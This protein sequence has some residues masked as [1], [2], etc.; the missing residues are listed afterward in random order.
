MAKKVHDLVIIG[1]GPAAL[2]AAIYTT[3]EDVETLLLEKLTVGGL[4]ATT[5]MIDNY[6]GFPDGV[7]GSELSNLLEKQ[8]KKFGSVIE[9]GTV[10]SIKNLGKDKLLVVDGSE[11]YA[12][13]V[14]IATGSDYN[15]LNIPGEKEYYGR[16]VHFCATC[17]G[18]FYRGRKIIV[19]G[20]GNSAFQESIYLTRFVE[21]ID[22]VVR[23]RIRASEILQ[24]DIKKYVDEGKITIHIGYTTEEIIAENNKVSG[25]IV[26]KDDKKT[27]I[28]ADGVFIFAGL[29]PN[30]AFLNSSGVELDELGF[31]KTDIRL[32]TNISGVFACGDVRSGATMQIAAAVGEGALAAYSIRDYLMELSKQNLYIA[33]A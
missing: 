24:D 5:D 8:A 29:K 3:R 6:P 28:L 10:E 25:V 9:Y 31:I 20:G 23:S 13:S 12:K 17:D 33:K 19:V 30:T 4:A 18:A 21:H 2:T 27:T 22:I 11:I 14:L 32:Q 1:A 26:A 7:E 16:G 15:H